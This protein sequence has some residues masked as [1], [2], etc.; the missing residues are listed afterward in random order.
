MHPVINV[1]VEDATAYARE[2]GS[3][4]VLEKA[5][6]SGADTVEVLVD[7]N[8]KE[9]RLDKGWGSNILL[10]LNITIT[11]VGKPRLFFEGKR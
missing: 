8:R 2:E 1:R 4:L 5:L 7:N 3:R 9:A 11:G 10:E 6:A